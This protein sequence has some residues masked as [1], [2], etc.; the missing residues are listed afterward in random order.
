[1]AN[2]GR[3]AAGLKELGAEDH[4]LP[5]AH[6]HW[7]SD[8]D[9]DQARRFRETFCGLPLDA[10]RRLLGHMVEAAEGDFEL[11]FAA[12]GRAALDDGDGEVR[13]LGIE[14]LWESKD[15]RLGE[16][17]LAM[18][19]GD[20]ADE[21]RAQAA[22][23]LGLFVMLHDFEELR[24]ELGRRIEAQLIAVIQG[25]TPL[26]IRRRAIESLGYSSR[27]EVPDLL[28]A[29][30]AEPQPE[31]KGSALMA[32]GRTA[33]S[34]LWGSTVLGELRNPS[35]AIRFQAVGAAGS[36]GLKSAVPELTELLNDSDRE[37]REQAIWALGEI[38]GQ[39][40][41]RALERMQRSA[42]AGERKLIEEALE[43]LD[44]QSGLDGFRL[45][46]V[47]DSGTGPLN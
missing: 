46:D 43:N 45:L 42:S 26:E 32:M 24:P 1:M 14:S 9:T 19:T 29:A 33:D 7:F 38:G 31:M 37:I 13:R 40:A 18:L 39:R 11:D 44:F 34:H 30:L 5:V 8:L 6:L 16:R 17:F 20:P 2:P 21:V 41:R 22:S 36:L 4:R 12:I 25:P 28:R 3:F 27:A 15:A 10:R 47:G 23:A 35:P